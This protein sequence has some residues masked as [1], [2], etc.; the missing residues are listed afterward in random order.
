[1]S[2]NPARNLEPNPDPQRATLANRG[3][4]H[5]GSESSSQI[6]SSPPIAAD[7]T[8]TDQLVHQPAGTLSTELKKK[9]LVTLSWAEGCEYHATCGTNREHKPNVQL[10][11][12]DL[13]QS[14]HRR[15]GLEA[16]RAAGDPRCA[17]FQRVVPDRRQRLHGLLADARRPLAMKGR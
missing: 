14:F 5:D 10:L 1:M 9:L 3:V 12:L 13:P 2:S 16:G 6:C 4:V 8:T 7:A 11:A 15:R 17:G